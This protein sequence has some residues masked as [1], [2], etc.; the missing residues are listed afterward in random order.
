[1]KTV[2]DSVRNRVLEFVLA[3]EGE[4]PDAGDGA[5]SATPTVAPQTVNNIFNTTI[6]AGQAIIGNQ[7][8]AT[9]GSGNLAKG[10][11]AGWTGKSAPLADIL[12]E[13]RREAGAIADEE[14]REEATAAVD[15][16]E[17]HAT[18]E[19][20]NLARI[21]Q[22]VELYATITTVASPTLRTLIE[23]F[24]PLLEHLLK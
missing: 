23:H 15:K 14:D 3:I 16:I 12:A 9:I 17:L 11:I 5:S 1:L 19:P 24:G 18:R 8:T 21:K 2:V 13:L 6:A 10:T 4:N 7:G 22:Y 20:L